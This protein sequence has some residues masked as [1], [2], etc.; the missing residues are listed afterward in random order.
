MQSRLAP[1]AASLSKESP[2]ALKYALCL[3]GFMHPNARLPIVELDD[4]TKAEVANA[5]AE[6]GDEDLAC[7]SENWRGPRV[8]KDAAATT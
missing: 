3:L 1:L 4:S 2:A 5:I 7:P 8:H 6:I